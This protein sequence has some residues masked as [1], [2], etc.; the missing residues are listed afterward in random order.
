LLQWNSPVAETRI[1]KHCATAS[2]TA[3]DDEVVDTFQ[4]DRHDGRCD[5]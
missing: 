3:K 4:A 1:G 5:A 2:R